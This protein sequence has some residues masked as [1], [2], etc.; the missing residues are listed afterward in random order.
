MCTKHYLKLE[1]QIDVEKEISLFNRQN[2]ARNFETLKGLIK[3]GSNL[4]LV[5]DIRFCFLFYPME[6]T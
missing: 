1:L 3:S 4:I 6:I 2:V 5:I